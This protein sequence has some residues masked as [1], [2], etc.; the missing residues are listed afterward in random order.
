MTNAGTVPKGDGG[1]TKLA[2]KPI[3]GGGGKTPNGIDIDGCCCWVER[4]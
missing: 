2:G 1:S 4:D 3:G